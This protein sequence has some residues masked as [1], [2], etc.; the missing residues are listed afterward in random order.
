MSLVEGGTKI[1]ENVMRHLGN[2]TL[3]KR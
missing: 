2:L 3:E 1:T